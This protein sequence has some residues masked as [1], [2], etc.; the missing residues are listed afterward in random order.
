MSKKY[1]TFAAEFINLYVMQEKNIPLLDCPVDYLIG[2]ASGKIL[3]EYGRFPCKIACGVYA[4]MVRG[5]AKATIN[6]TR[7]EF[8]AN[9]LLFLEPG[10]F[11]L[12]HEFSEDALVYYVLFS[13]SFLDKHTFI[14]SRLNFVPGQ[15]NQFLV[16]LEPERGELVSCLYDVLL[17]AS[18][19]HPSALSTEKMVHVYNLFRAS[20]A[21]LARSAEDEQA[22]QIKDR[23][24]ELYQTYCQLVLKNY[25]RLHHVGQ[26]AE[27]MHITL[28]HLCA[29][30]RQASNRTAGDIIEEAILTDAKAQLKLTNLPIKEVAL[31]LGFEN[32]AFFNRFFK[33]HIGQTPK[34]YRNTND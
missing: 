5:T 2:D 15:L 9:D 16:H 29:T 20:Y 17:K 12:I 31:S 24:T 30:I 4:F 1:R 14:N 13:A 21:D 34:V 3:N 33:Q 23:K 8:H 25:Q 28:P 26:Y 6:I 11:L 22:V 18:N 27:L 7:C 19:C 32:V 10:S